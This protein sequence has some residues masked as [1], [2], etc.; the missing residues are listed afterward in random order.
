M[1]F[2]MLWLGLAVVTGTEARTPAEKPPPPPLQHPTMG[3]ENGCFVES[4][5]FSDAFQE[6]YGSTAWVRLLQWGATEE[7]EVV[8]GH[9]V[10]VCQVRDRLWCWDINSGFSVL[11][12]PPALRDLLWNTFGVPVFEQYLG[13]NLELLAFECEAHDGLHLANAG[14]HDP[15]CALRTELCACGNPTPR[16]C[17]VEEPGPA[18]PRPMAMASGA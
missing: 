11:P 1:K 5:V 16:L 14:V 3:V 6:K 13:P 7:E 4:V 8:A 18:C 2:A 15:G 9:A 10:A 12:V 17:A